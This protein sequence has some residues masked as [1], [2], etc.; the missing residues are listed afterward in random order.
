MNKGG[1]VV[2]SIPNLMHYT[3]IRQ[4]VNGRFQ[5]SDGGLLDRTHIH[6]FTCH[7]IV[8]MFRE[9]GF[10]IEEMLSAMV[11]KPSEEDNRLIETLL[12]F[13]RDTNRGMYETFQYNIRARKN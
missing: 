13:S 2:T 12:S 6:F 11:G 5:Y 4:L 10:E 3:V 9:T 7:E 8:K 1:I